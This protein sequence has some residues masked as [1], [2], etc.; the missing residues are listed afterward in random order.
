MIVKY[1]LHSFLSTDSDVTVAL[2][3]VVAILI[4]DGVIGFFDVVVDVAVVVVIFAVM[5]SS[6]IFLL[7]ILD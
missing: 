1:S 2:V 6:I 5:V 3:A 4:L 7:I